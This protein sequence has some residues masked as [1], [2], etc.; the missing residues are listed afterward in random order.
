MK[1]ALLSVF[2]LI[3][4]LPVDA[5]VNKYASYPIYKGTH[6]GLT[7]SPVQSFFRIYAPTAEKAQLI[8]YQQGDGG[9]QVGLVNMN[10]DVQGTWIAT[11]K[12]DLKG[13]FYVFK[14]M[15]NGKWL[16]EVPDPYAKAV[17]INGK[18]AMVIE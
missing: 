16:T 2:L 1:N 14:V 12:G 3:I 6:L 8:F 15:I 5:Q 11:S 17:G 7:Y 18:R 4:L 10:K 9:S 13:R